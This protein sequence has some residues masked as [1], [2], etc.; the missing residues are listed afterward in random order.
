MINHFFSK[1]RNKARRLT[2]QAY[3]PLYRPTCTIK[4]EK[5]RHKNQ[6]GKEMIISTNDI[7]V[8]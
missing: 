4:Q 2:N 8:D 6:K 3:S 7:I 5:N 1:I